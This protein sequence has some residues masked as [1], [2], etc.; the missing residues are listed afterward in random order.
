M[1]NKIL[2]LFIFSLFLFSCGTKSVSL[3]VVRP[4]EVNLKG[5]DKIAV[6]QILNARGLTNVHSEDL[7]EEITAKLVASERFDVV[8]RQHLKTIMQEQSLGLTGM[9]DEQSAPKIGR[10]LGVSV[11]IFGRIQQDGYKEELKRDKPYKDKEGKTHQR[12]NRVG[13]YNLSAA[14]KLI[15]VQTGKILAAKNFAAVK[16]SKQSAIDKTPAKIDRS[17]LYRQ[18]LNQLGNQFIKTIAPF[19]AR[20]SAK[21]EMDDAIPRAERAVAMFKVGEWDD[22]I[23]LLQTATKKKKLK[24]VIR[25]KAFYNLGLAQTYQGQ[26]DLA[27]Q[28]IKKAIDLN[29]KSSRYMNALRNVKN[30]QKKAEELEQQL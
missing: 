5:Y 17:I 20:V 10:L 12:R 21:F 28:N 2:I 4:A 30:E 14:L 3:M 24:K 15:D 18:A 8:D 29:P 11:L 13:R 27:I 19:K 16:S 26:Y 23:K 6:G 25:A 1:Q 9:I 22:G 7:A